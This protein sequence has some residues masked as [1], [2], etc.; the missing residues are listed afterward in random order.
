MSGSGTASCGVQAEE[1]RAVPAAGCGREWG[2]AW[3]KQTQ[4]PRVSFG[5][6]ELGFLLCVMGS[7]EVRRSNMIKCVLKDISGISAR[8][9]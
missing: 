6:K 4:R 3:G 8:V 9:N 7:L 1:G 2:Q 5:T